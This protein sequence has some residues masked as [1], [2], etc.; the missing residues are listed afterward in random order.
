RR[1]ARTRHPPAVALD[2]AAQLTAASLLLE[3]GGERIGE[4]SL[5]GL[6]FA[7]RPAWVPQLDPSTSRKFSREPAWRSSFIGAY[8]GSLYQARA[9]SIDGNSIMVMLVMSRAPFQDLPRIRRS[10]DI[11]SAVL[12]DQLVHTHFRSP[13]PAIR[14]RV[15]GPEITI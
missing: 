9:C 8:S 10:C 2:A 7:H 12:R 5:H 13:L 14:T 6:H 11:T 3:E 15:I 1:A 4:G